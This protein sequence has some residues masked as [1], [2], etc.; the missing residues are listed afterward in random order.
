MNENDAETESGTQSEIYVPETKSNF[1]RYAITGLVAIAIL[2]WGLWELKRIT[3]PDSVTQ[4]PPP[5]LAADSEPFSTPTLDA[6]ETAS[7]T[8]V[9][10]STAPTDREDPYT[11][12]LYPFAA[13]PPGY[14][15]W[16]CFSIPA[17]GTSWGAILVG[18]ESA[19]TRYDS[20][21][22][23]V[24]VDGLNKLPIEVDPQT[25]P[26]TWDPVASMVK[27]GTVACSQ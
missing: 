3:T 25:A 18:G 14:E 4:G 23:V 16:D 26:A 20:H 17:G 6:P 21:S 22:A 12:V 1:P 5:T 7:P 24:F 8:T 9:P 2:A 27:P 19:A 10:Y 13:P 11:H 15:G